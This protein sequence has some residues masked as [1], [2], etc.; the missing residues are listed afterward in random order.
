VQEGRER[1]LLADDAP[2]LECHADGDGD[3][4]QLCRPEG[5]FA[6]G[7]CDRAA[8]VG[9][10]CERRIDAGVE[11]RDAL[12]RQRLALDDGVGVGYRFERAGALGAELGRRGVREPRS[13]RRQLQRLEGGAIHAA[14]VGGG[15]VSDTRPVTR[16][17]CAPRRGVRHLCGLPVPGR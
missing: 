12:G 5:P 17:R 6:R 7:T 15:L 3:R 14:S 10:A 2:R 16:R 4:V 1:A 8:D 11:E 9:D 13:D